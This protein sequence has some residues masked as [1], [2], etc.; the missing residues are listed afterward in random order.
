MVKIPCPK[1]NALAELFADRETTG[2]KATIEDC[3]VLLEI[4]E[5]AEMN[6]TKQVTFLMDYRPHK[7]E[8]LLNPLLSQAQGPSLS[9]CFHDISIRVDDLIKSS[10]PSRYYS[11]ALGGRGGSGGNGF[12]RYGRG[13]SSCFFLTDILRKLVYFNKIHIVEVLF[14]RFFIN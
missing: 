13:V 1:R 10:S 11:E 4:L 9:V 12:P 3:R 7:S 5:L 6:N 14:R 8:S 2:G